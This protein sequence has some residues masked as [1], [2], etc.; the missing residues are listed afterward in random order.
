MKKILFIAIALISFNYANAQSN[1]IKVNPIGLLVGV[2]NAGYEFKTN[3][4]QSATISGLYFDILDITGYG[5]GAEYRFYFGGEALNGWHAGPSLGFFALEDNANNS[6]SVFAIGG[7][8]GHQWVFGSGFL[9]DVFAG[10]GVVTGGDNLS[11]LNSANFSFGVS[12]GYA[13]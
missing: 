5:A 13:W 4:A 10:A 8:V 1:A 11:G 6:A 12:L 7:E 2:G 9:V 3:D